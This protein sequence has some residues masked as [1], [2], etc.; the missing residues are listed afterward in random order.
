M[1]KAVKKTEIPVENK[2]LEQ[3][4]NE[5]FDK[6]EKIADEALK[7]PEVVEEKAPEV[8]EEK[9]PEVVEEK[10]PEVVEEK[11]PEVVEEKAPEVVEEKAPEDDDDDD[12]DEEDEEENNDEEI[13]EL[14]KSTEEKIIAIIKSE[15]NFNY[16]N[17]GRHLKD[18]YSK[19]NLKA[20]YVEFKLSNALTSASH[21]E[22]LKLL[23]ESFD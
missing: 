16:L 20:F 10:A 18:D 11:A 23:G 1:A 2:T 12:D 19:E 14:E 7:A 21:Y 8:V 4:T 17:C 15:N 9:A 3:S 13:P 6:I 5:T 22:L